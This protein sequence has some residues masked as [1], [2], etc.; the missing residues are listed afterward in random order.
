MSRWNAFI[1]IGCDSCITA[2]EETDSKTMADARREVAGKGWEFRRGLDYCPGCVANL[3]MVRQMLREIE[4][5]R[6]DA[7]KAGKKRK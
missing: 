4:L 5:K 6:R 7:V 1:E 3:P 2:H